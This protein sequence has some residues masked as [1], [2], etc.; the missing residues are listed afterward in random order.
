MTKAS[1]FDEGE[2]LLTRDDI[3]TLRRLVQFAEM[4]KEQ[5]DSPAEK[6]MVGFMEGVCQ[7]F[8]EELEKLG[9]PPAP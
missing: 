4:M 1:K 7:Q 5:T 2:I 6:M 8:I 3:P 9:R